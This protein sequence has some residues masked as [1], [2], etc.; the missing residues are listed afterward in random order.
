MIIYNITYRH[1]IIE[2]FKKSFLHIATKIFIRLNQ[3][4]YLSRIYN[5]IKKIFK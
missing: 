5:K 3:I 4:N 1:L 2:M